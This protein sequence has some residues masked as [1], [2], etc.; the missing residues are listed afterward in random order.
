MGME[1]TSLAAGPQKAIDIMAMGKFLPNIPGIGF[2]GEPLAAAKK[3]GKCAVLG[4][5]ISGQWAAELLL[6]YG[7]EVSFIDQKSEDELTEA[8]D[9][10]SG[11]PVKW[12][13][14]KD[15]EKG[16]N[17]QELIVI[18]PGVPWKFPGLQ[19]AMRKTPVTGEMEL[20]A[21]MLRVPII[22][23]SGSNGKTTTTGLVGH[24][25]RKNG[26]SVFVGGNI[27]EPLSRFILSGQKARAVIVEASSYQLETVKKFHAS[28]AALLNISPDH[29]DRYDDMAE[30]FKAKNKIFSNQTCDD[31]AVLNEDDVLLAHKSTRA[32]RF[33]FSRKAAP[34]FGAWVN[35]GRVIVNVDGREVASR[36]WRDFKLEGVHN[37]ENVMAAVGLALS[38]GVSAQAALDAATTFTPQRHRL[39]LVAEREG[40]RYYDDSKGTNVGAVMMALESF[41]RPVVLIAGGQGK[42]QDFSALYK[43]V[44]DKVSQLI[45]IGADRA[46]IEFA[47]KGAAPI[48]LADSMAEAV[49]LAHAA[50]SKGAVVLLSPACAS[51]DM[52]RDYR[53]R[54]DIFA[55]EVKGL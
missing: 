38:L 43:P 53:H 33:G 41:E 23:I 9:R 15:A 1:A 19:K 16:F 55:Q 35:N 3:F 34:K 10:F 12:F 52:F 28:A 8:M 18:S 48:T 44:L 11:M 42:G 17:G 27:G 14:G 45:L 51:F 37:Q 24:I 2:E 5:G 36:E 25:C 46:K 13:V 21:S 20:A 6:E 54:G 26:V 49:K 40:V 7:A 22:A 31:L 29:L 32:R 4:V 50:A 47:L 39:E 30:Y